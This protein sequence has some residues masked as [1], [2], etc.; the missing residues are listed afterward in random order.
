MNANRITNNHGF[1]LVELMI[2]VSIVAILTAIA[3]PSYQGQ[4]RR[5]RRSEGQV[6]LLAI[7]IAQEKMRANCTQYA[8][9]VAGTPNCDAA[10][11]PPYALGLSATTPEGDYHLS[12]SGVSATGFTASATPVGDQAKDTAG[13]VACDPLTIDQDGNREPRECW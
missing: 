4:I 13:G 6:A 7:A 10:E 1:T 8:S 3:L 9:T 11:S 2:A 5:S 12:L